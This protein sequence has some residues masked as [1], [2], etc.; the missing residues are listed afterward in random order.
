VAVY[1]IYLIL[2]PCAIHI[3]L[4]CTMTKQMHIYFTNLSH[5]SYMFRHFCVIL[6]ELEIC[7]LPSYKNISNAAVGNTIYNFTYFIFF[8]K[9]HCL[10]TLKY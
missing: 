1:K 4:F 10:K 2:T 8:V 7:T 6:R 9:S 5:F 3:L